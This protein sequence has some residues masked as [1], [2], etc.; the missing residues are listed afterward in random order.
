[1]KHMTHGDFVLRAAVCV[2][3][4][5]GSA[6]VLLF[7]GAAAGQAP[8][9]ELPLRTRVEAFKGSGT[10]E[11]LH[12]R[13]SIPVRETAVLIC[14]LWD[15]HWCSGS[16]MRV[17]ILA[18][19]IAAEVE[20]ARAKGILI[21]HAPSDTMAFYQDHPARK[22]VLALAPVEPPANLA[23]SDPLL[24]ID[25]SGGGCETGEK[26][27][28]PWPWT[29]EHPAVSVAAND[30]ISEKGSE[31]YSLLSQRGI[32]NLLVMGVHTNFCIL[33]RTFAIRQMTR[34][35]IRCVLVRDLTDS[36]YDP[37]KAPFVS[38]DRG[39][40]L[41]IEHIEKYW[42]P[43]MLSADLHRALMQVPGSARE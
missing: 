26:A 41:V 7:A 39:T 6:L 12:F 28:Q 33:N 29:R 40:E 22:R 24:P 20:R 9:L 18:P 32:K 43:T 1:M 38:H 4:L 31:I 37:K 34:W 16:E 42:C 30:A 3:V 14:D 10:W 15:H 27:S 17:G 13:K 19:K 25:S 36:M 2:P 5:L 11:E 35:G 21:I 23:L 8:Q